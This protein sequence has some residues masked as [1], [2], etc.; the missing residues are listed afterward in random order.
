[1]S[2]AVSTAV[3]S[4]L[5]CTRTVLVPICSPLRMMAKFAAASPPGSRPCASPVHGPNASAAIANNNVENSRIQTSL[6]VDNWCVNQPTTRPSGYR[7]HRS[8]GGS[9]EPRQQREH[10]R[11]QRLPV[12][13]IP[14]LAVPAPDYPVVLDAGCQQTEAEILPR[15]HR[16]RGDRREFDTH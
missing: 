9:P 15:L 5:R 7:S 16:S 13:L 6:G 11:M 8:P 1:M 10:D 2:V 14:A 3:S 4:P 12:L